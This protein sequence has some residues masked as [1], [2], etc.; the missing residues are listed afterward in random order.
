MVFLL[1]TLVSASE[2]HLIYINDISFPASVTIAVGDTVTWVNN[3]SITHT[4]TDTTT[5]WFDS[6]DVAPGENWSFTFYHVGTHPYYCIYAPEAMTGAID[7]IVP[8]Y[9]S[10]GNTTYTLTEFNAYNTT[11]LQGLVVENYSGVELL[12]E[13]L[14]VYF[15][16]TTLRKKWLPTSNIYGIQDLALY[17]V[18]VNVK[19]Q[20]RYDVI[21]HCY[22]QSSNNQTYCNE[23][24]VTNL[25]PYDFNGTQ[26]ATISMQLQN[27]YQTVYKKLLRLQDYTKEYVESQTMNI[28][29]IQQAIIGW[30][31]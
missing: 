17:P 21:Q 28:I 27:R 7:V 30:F 22:E 25:V 4:I 15:S 29:N 26:V 2:E 6:G 20:L 13:H 10:M 8:T 14:N 31:T 18:K 11:Q 23:V 1:V 9:T 24:L 5:Y 12:W 16:Y 19:T 3:H